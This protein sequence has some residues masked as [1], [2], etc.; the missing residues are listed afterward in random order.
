MSAV[1]R[2]NLIAAIAGLG[3]TVL[4]IVLAVNLIPA[5]QPQPAHVS[6]VRECLH[7]MARSGVDEQDAK[8]EC[9]QF[10]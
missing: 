7:D 8:A 5:G 2:R 6:V 10:R 9:E 4:L 3:I 1:A